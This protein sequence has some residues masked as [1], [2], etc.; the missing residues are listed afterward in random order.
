ME[1]G[2]VRVRELWKDGFFQLPCVF[3]VVQ[4]NPRPNF[5]VLNE[6]GMTVMPWVTKARLK[7][8]LIALERG[9]EDETT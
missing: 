9:A 6:Q 7:E 3:Q 5:Y 2:D 1:I 4:K 8:T